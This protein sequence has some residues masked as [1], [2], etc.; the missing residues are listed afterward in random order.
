MS[1]YKKNTQ[2]TAKSPV[3]KPA[4]NRPASTVGAISE[5]WLLAGCLVLTFA[6]FANTFGAGF[7]NWDDHG[8]LWLNPMVK[9]LGSMDLGQIF[10]GHTHG[11]YSP[12]V[13]LSYCFEHSFDTIVAPGK[14]VV[15]NFQP[16]L[17]HFDNVLLHV[18]TTAI[19]FFFFR[20]LG[21]R[22]WGLA[23]GTALFGIH[24]MRSESVA[25]VTERKDVLYG[26]FYI[27][28]LLSYWKYLTEQ[29]SK[30]YVFT[31]L[32]G[33]LSLFSKIQAV[34]LPLSMLAMDWL[35][36]RD[37]KSIKI[38]LEKVPF[39]GLSLV[40][41][42]VGIH[43]LGEAEGFKD[44]GYSLVERFFFATTSLWNY[45][46]KVPV[47]LGL[48]AYY[49]YPKLGNMPAL[50]YASPLALAAIGWWIWGTTKHG[51]TVAFGFLFF[52]VNIHL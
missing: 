19:A 4:T 48:S 10:S 16:F 44:T 40:F 26:L 14:M 11:N 6:V 51:K 28:A 1:K 29:K 25:W 45:L 18:A 2:P 38:W 43:F 21:V 39:F 9:P 47:P 27:A 13:I 32:F 41:G 20:A 7:V 46:Y 22:G 50:Y 8:Y 34:S 35:A 33:L 52:L 49:P 5:H 15:E 23:L 42:L 24:P 36:G 17:Y 37:L 3:S 12:M 31:L 30:Y